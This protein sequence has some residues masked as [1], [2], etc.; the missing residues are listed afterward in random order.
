MHARANRNNHLLLSPAIRLL[1]RLSLP[2]KFALISLFFAIPLGLVLYFLHVKM[3]EQIRVAELEIKG[4]D[5]LVPLNALYN[6]LPQT[7]SLANA[8]LKKQPFAIEH[9]PNR[10]SEIDSIMNNLADVDAKLGDALNTHT[11]FRVLRD[12]WEDLKTQLG[13]L[14]PE[15]S[16]ELF[17]KL[18][19]Q[20]EDLSGY[21]GDQ[22]TL[23]LD[24]DLDSYYLMDAILLKIPENVNI[25]SRTR[26]MVGRSMSTGGLTESDFNILLS[27]GNLLRFNLKK[28]DR[29]L[30]V[31]FDNNPTQTLE[32]AL[33][34]P[35][36]QY[37]SATSALLQLVD[38]TLT[39]NG[40]QRF[41]DDQY[42]NAAATVLASNMRL[43]ER[44]AQQLK[45]V[46][47]TRSAKVSGQFWMLILFAFGAI[48][49]VTYLW[50]AFY[51]T[52]MNTV[53]SLQDATA[54]LAGGGE[55][56]LVDLETRDELGQVSSAFNSVAR[57][58]IE[59][60]RNYRSIFDGSVD[61]IFR[62]SPEGKYLEANAALARIYKYETVDDFIQGTGSAANLYIDPN[63]R[64]QFREAIER[65]GQI[66]DFEAEVRCADGSTVW[67]NENA[68]LIRDEQGR[69]TFYEGVVRDI[70][71]KKRAE[72]ALQQAIQDANSANRAKS[73]FLANMSH[74]IR[75]P[76]NAILGFAEL[77]KGL[78]QGD[79][80]QSYVNAI[81]SSGRTLLS[82]IND[83]LDLSKIE[84][85]KLE[86]EYDAMDV[87]VVLRDVQ[88]IFS[89]KAEQKGLDLE[90]EIASD[91]PSSLFLDE[92]R[93]RQIF[94]NVVGN[95][96]K[97]TERGH[98]RMSASINPQNSTATEVELQIE[99]EDTG[100]G[101]SEPEQTRIFEEF[102]QQSGQKTKRF[103]GTGLGLSITKRLVEMMKGSVTL[104]SKEGVGST[105]RFVFPGIKVAQ[106]TSRRRVEASQQAYELRD[107]QPCKV[108][109]ADD[110]SMNR[111]LIR[112]FFHGTEH[113]LIEAANGKEAVE[114]A[115]SERPDIILMDVRMPVMDGTQATRMLK[116]DDV[117]KHIP[118]IVVTASAMHSEELALKPICDGFLRKPISQSDLAGQMRA[119][120][121]T[122]RKPDGADLGK[123]PQKPV[124]VQPESEPLPAQ[125][126]ERLAPLR[127][128][129]ESLVEAPM[130][131]E[132]EKFG[133]KLLE[134]AAAE[135]NRCLNDY[136]ERLINLAVR[137]DMI[138]METTL[139][140]FGP[141]FI[142]T[143]SQPIPST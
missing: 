117:L 79:R 65:E 63:R 99:V 22:S 37:I 16:D 57:Q 111:D 132:V 81:T 5:Y 1:N 120:C 64:T 29:G 68:R 77:L 43:W 19:V 17:Q 35:L 71:Q 110:I 95:A 61:G 122:I 98:V 75:T 8:Y 13:K 119:F 137:F 50:I 38:D 15:I 92:V 142:D 104:R 115:G 125:L 36:A 130:V 67:I 28:L 114:L 62:T 105:F 86:L 135:N 40:R 26:R 90:L 53:H 100:I 34:Q 82:I 42:Q 31:A 59:T 41:S 138:F 72:A 4:V 2:Q 30:N 116:S 109:I 93:L 12:T 56:V 124:A 51:R 44:A 88:Y 76:M 73:E 54:R 126:R 74:E 139:A 47:Q 84:A 58:L 48:L 27:E 39:P 127:E 70:T 91:I 123:A 9:Y 87:A 97:F 18:I 118:I 136:A 60:G 133:R 143:H 52:I 96:I 24:P 66:T 3:R 32:A 102:V 129:W 106:S 107:L 112:A 11:R 49:V 7:L 83:I 6:E 46:L 134:I 14:T 141:I 55:D 45:H 131:G 113:E 21:I 78:V 69:P 80:Q 121:K 89:Q 23:I 108:L 10:Q 85:G 140:D 20:V 101:I 25:V 103:G 128:E 33:N 94:F